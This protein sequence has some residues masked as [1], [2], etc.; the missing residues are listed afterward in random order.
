MTTFG[1][2]DR[3]GQFRGLFPHDGD[4]VCSPCGGTESALDERNTRAAA[5]AA[6]GRG[7]VAAE[8]VALDRL[9]VME[10]GRIVDTIADIVE[11]A[12][13]GKRWVDD[14]TGHSFVPW[15]DAIAC[16]ILSSLRGAGYSIVK[17]A[18]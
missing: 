3:C 13:S 10:H 1:F 15:P 12:Q 11:D 14:N 17:E 4:G 7:D 16:K 5:I 18:S 9:A 6:R 2:C 8:R